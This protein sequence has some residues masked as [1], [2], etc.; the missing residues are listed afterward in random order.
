MVVPDDVL[1]VVPFGAI[2]VPPAGLAP[3]VPVLP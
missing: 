2:V 3:T 1:T